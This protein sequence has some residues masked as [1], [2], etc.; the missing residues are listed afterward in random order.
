MKS[1][2]ARALLEKDGY[3]ELPKAKKKSFL[4]LIW[5]VLREPMIL[6]LLTGAGI[7]LAIG[8]IHDSLLLLASVLVIVFIA[9]FQERRSTRAVEALRD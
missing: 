7:Y 5:E 9:I 1:D 6:L 4:L 2:Q 8:E 3:N